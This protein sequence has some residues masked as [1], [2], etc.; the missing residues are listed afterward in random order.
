MF[1]LPETLLLLR[2]SDNAVLRIQVTFQS[3]IEGH[4]QSIVRIYIYMIHIQL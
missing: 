3:L 4:G 2:R 1:R